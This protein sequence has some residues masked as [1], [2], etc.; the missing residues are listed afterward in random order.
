MGR[1]KESRTVTRVGG[2]LLSPAREHDF[3][4]GRTST[5]FVSG[6]PAGNLLSMFDASRRTLRDAIEKAE[7]TPEQILCIVRNLPHEG[8]QADANVA[9]FCSKVEC[10]NRVQGIFGGDVVRKLVEAIEK[11]Q[12]RCPSTAV[13][14]IINLSLKRP[15]KANDRF[16]DRVG[17]NRWRGLP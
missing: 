15:V 8:L 16:E 12:A 9:H 4:N 1:H 2:K 10:G 7:E 14:E 5:T 17:E 3:R 11:E 13:L 6:F